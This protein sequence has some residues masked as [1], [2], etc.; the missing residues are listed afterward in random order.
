MTENNDVDNIDSNVIKCNC[1]DKSQCPV[2]KKCKIKNVIYQAEVIC[3]DNSETYIGLTSTEFKTRYNSHKHSFN[4]NSKRYSTELSKH[5][6]SLKDSNQNFK[7]KWKLIC[8]ARPYN[9]IS[10]RCHLCICEKYFI[11]CKYRMA[12]L[13]KRSELISKCRHQNKFSIGTV[14]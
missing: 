4:D 10:K 3:G 11:I 12:T 1:R 7:I 5:I 6:W 9:N 8:Q 14:T 13:N 2:E